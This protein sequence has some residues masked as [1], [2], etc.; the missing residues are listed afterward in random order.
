MTMER[1][2]RRAV[3]KIDPDQPLYGVQTLEGVRSDSLAP[4]RL[5]AVLLALFAGVALAITAAGIMGVMALSVSQRTQ[6][7]GIRMALG[8]SPT[9]VLTMVVSQGM[10]LVLA[11]LALGIAGSLAATRVMGGL[12]YGVAPTDPAT[13]VAVSAALA[14]CAAAACILPARRAATIDPMKALRSE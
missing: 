11:G 7:I 14:L 4:K 6:E 13:F 3:Y 1:A 9:R 12:L 10:W 8:A 2:V 5:T